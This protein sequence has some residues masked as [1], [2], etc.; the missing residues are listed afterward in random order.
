MTVT[1]RREYEDEQIA[2]CNPPLHTTV[3]VYDD[4][5][6]GA[7]PPA[8][9]RPVA[10]RT[11]DD[12]LT[13][14]GSAVASLALVWLL[15]G[16]VLPFSGR[17]GFV[18]CWFGVFVAFHAALTAMAQPWPIVVDRVA[19]AVVHGGAAAAFLALA[20]TVF[21]TFH[22]GWPAY[23]HLNF[24]TDDMSGVGPTTPLDKGGV[25][26]AVVGSLIEVGIAVVLSVP[27]GFA[28]AVYLTEVGGRMA[29]V[30]RTVIEAMTALPDLV[31]GL[32]IYAVF[33]VGLGNK[34]TGIAAALALSITMLPIIARS[35]EVVLRNVPAGL[36]EAAYALG[37][38]QWRSVVSV[39]LPTAKAG[40]GTALILGVARGI[41]ET[42][43]VIIASGASTFVNSDPFQDPM[44]SLPLFI[45]TSVRSGQPLMITR[46]YGAA[47]MLLAVVVVLFVLIRVIARHRGSDR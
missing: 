36:R 37:S 21:Y 47:S 42:A 17:L 8:R 2:R 22:K 28:T 16:H 20:A 23:T 1:A 10:A 32:F 43:P 11:A 27:L 3:V 13:F 46:A 30:V 26:H 14:V 29:R 35:S 6:S 45:Y 9:P 15:Y 24:F 33:I 38:T 40:L 5:S 34:R 25:V 7:P 41:G 18:L 31:A 19:S 4:E 44:N 39:V 12:W